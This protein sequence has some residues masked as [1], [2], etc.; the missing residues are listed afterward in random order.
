MQL[1]LLSFVGLSTVA[2]NDSVDV[3]L[4]SNNKFEAL[5]LLRIMLQDLLPWIGK[6]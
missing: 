3:F 2:A 6:Y 4:A 5:I 1:T